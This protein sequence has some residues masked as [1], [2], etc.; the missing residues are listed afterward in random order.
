MNENNY[1]KK[2]VRIIL[3]SASIVQAAKLCKQAD[4]QEGGDESV[5]LTQEYIRKVVEDVGEDEDFKCGSWN[6]LKNGKLEQVVAI[7][8]SRTSNALGDLTVTLKD[9][10]GSIT[11]TIYYKVLNEGGY[12]KNITLG[13]SLILQIVLVFSPKPSIYYHNITMRHFVKVFPK[14]TVSG[15]GSCVGGSG[16]LNEEEIIKILDEEA[17]I[18]ALEE[19]AR[20]EQEW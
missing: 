12:G 2:P 19:E 20:A 18:L 15:N 11:G 8:K 9:L 17:L 5:L 13:A 14:D 6:Y 4:I 10:S 16:M 3:G 1:L 7:I